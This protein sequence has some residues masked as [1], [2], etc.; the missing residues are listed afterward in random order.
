MPIRD[1]PLK[2]AVEC[3]P[4]DSGTIRESRRQCLTRTSQQVLLKT[5]AL[6]LIVVKLRA[7]NPR[8]GV[9]QTRSTERQTVSIAAVRFTAPIRRFEGP[10][11]SVIVDA[12]PRDVGSPVQSS[13]AVFH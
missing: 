9:G 12:L 8:T 13:Q 11:N 4:P 7:D 5:L 6:N 2:I 10:R 1:L 3:C